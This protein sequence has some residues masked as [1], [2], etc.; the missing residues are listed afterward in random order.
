[1]YIPQVLQ[2][3]RIFPGSF[4]WTPVFFFRVFCTS[5]GHVPH[6]LSVCGMFIQDIYSPIY[7][8]TSR[9]CSGNS[10]FVSGHLPRHQGCVFRVF[11]IF[12]ETITWTPGLFF[13]V[14]R[15]LLGHVLHFY[16][17]VTYLSANYLCTFCR[18]FGHFA[19]GNP[20]P[21]LPTPVPLNPRLFPSERVQERPNQPRNEWDIAN[22]DEFHEISYNSLNSGQKI[23]FLDSFWRRLVLPVTVSTD[24]T[25]PNLYRI[26]EPVPFPNYMSQNVWKTWQQQPWCLGKCPGG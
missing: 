24:T 15:T 6:F 26:P 1:M 5:L 4:T 12:F 17:C 8:C 2:K 7:L 13:W 11:H 9:R 19:F 22:F 21:C 16:L 20:F 14:F 3:F 25:T 23:M 18:C 10:A